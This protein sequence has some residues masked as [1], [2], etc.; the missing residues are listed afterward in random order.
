MTLHA[1][2]IITNT[3]RSTVLFQFH[4]HLL[5]FFWPSQLLLSNTDQ[6]VPVQNIKQSTERQRALEQEQVSLFNEVGVVGKLLR[7]GI[8]MRD[9]VR[10][11]SHGN[12]DEKSVAGSPHRGTQLSASR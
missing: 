3:P 5:P 2:R 10:K 4:H 6:N 11:F 8:M 7:M 1:H 12:Y 9:L